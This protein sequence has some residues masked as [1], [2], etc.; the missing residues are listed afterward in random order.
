MSCENTRNV[1]KNERQYIRQIIQLGI[2]GMQR[3][4]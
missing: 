4:F 3:T 2:P 1:F